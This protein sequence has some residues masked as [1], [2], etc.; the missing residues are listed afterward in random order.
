MLI[1]EDFT[2]L[3]VEKNIWKHIIAFN[4]QV[5]LQY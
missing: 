5:L 1:V 2:F 4:V 3:M